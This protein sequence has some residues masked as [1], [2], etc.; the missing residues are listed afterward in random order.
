MVLKVILLGQAGAGKTAL[1]ARFIDDVYHAS[2]KATLGADMRDKTVSI[3]D[4]QVVLQIWDTAGQERFNSLTSMYLKG[5]DMCL[6][7]YDLTRADSFDA[8][9]QWRTQ[10]L[11]ATN[12]PADFPFV[13][14][15][16]K[17]DVAAQRAVSQRRANAWCQ[18]NGDM[19][20]LEVSAK[21]GTNVRLCF[22]NL[23]RK[24][25]KKMQEDR[26]AQQAASAAAADSG[27]SPAPGSR[28]VQ[29]GSDLR[30]LQPAKRKGKS[31]C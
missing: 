29:L 16:N 19:P 6:L 21:E 20:Y 15:G 9:A 30:D 28:G 3:G 7:C 31:C 24:A 8:L 26:K 22:M 18:Q 23:A 2:Y 12:S 4:E 5:A 10:F 25:V 14:V 17:C 13:C 27:A 11:A 1:C